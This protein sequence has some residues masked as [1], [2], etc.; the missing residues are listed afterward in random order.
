LVGAGDIVAKATDEDSM[1]MYEIKNDRAL[2]KHERECVDLT[3]LD[4]PSAD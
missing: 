4:L 2:E 3:G 1:T